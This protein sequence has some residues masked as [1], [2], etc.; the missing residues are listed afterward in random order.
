MSGI[1]VALFPYIFLSEGVS[2]KKNPMHDVACFHKSVNE[3]YLNRFKHVHFHITNRKEMLHQ[4]HIVCVV[5][6]H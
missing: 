5:F 2:V 1:I 4:Y 3:S 6:I